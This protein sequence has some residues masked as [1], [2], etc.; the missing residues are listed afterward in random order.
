MTTYLSDI[1]ALLEPP[2]TGQR[3]L[4]QDLT[5]VCEQGYNLAGTEGAN[6]RAIG[7]GGTC[8]A[9]QTCN[10]CQTCMRP[11]LF[12]VRGVDREQYILCRCDKKAAIRIGGSATNGSIQR[13]LPQD[14]PVIGRDGIEHPIAG[15]RI[16]AP[17]ARRH[18]TAEVFLTAA[19]FAPKIAT[20][21]AAPIRE[22]ES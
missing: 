4:P 10:L 13:R 19:A 9:D 12:A 3:I 15:R 6:N 21:E 18:P 11:E 17:V 8:T 22:I 7:G 14:L 1:G 16:D 20:P 5:I 2:Y